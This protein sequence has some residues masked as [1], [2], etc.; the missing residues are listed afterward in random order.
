L[1]QEN[2]VPRCFLLIV[3]LLAFVTTVTAA[4]QDEDLQRAL[5]LE[6]TVQKII[7]RAEPA[8]ACLVISRSD[9]YARFGQGPAADNAGKLGPFDA[10]VLK[11]HRLFAELSAADKKALVRKLDL[12]ASGQVPEAS[13]SGIVIADKGQI[14]TPYHAVY[15]AT[16]IFVRLPE[17][18]GSYA[19]VFAADPRSDL[20]VLRLLRPK[21]ALKSVQ[22][23]D[24]GKVERGQFVVG[25]ANAFA[26]GFPDAKPS[27]AWGMI[28][29]VRQRLPLIPDGDAKGKSI[30]HY[31]TL[32]QTD[33][34][35]NLGTS[36]GVLFN[37]QGEAIAL[38]STV[39]GGTPGPDVAGTFAIPFDDGLRRII[40]VLQKG[41][42]VEYGFLGV[43]F[44]PHSDKTEGVVLK[45]VTDGSPAD[46]GG[47]KE[48]HA[49]MAVDGQP[50]RDN[51]ELLRALSTRLAGTKVRLDVKKPGVAARDTVEIILAKYLVTGK[52]IA[53]ERGSR[54]FFRG[55]RVD[56]T[57]LI[58]QQPGFTAGVIPRGVL[59]SE[60]MPDT[61]AARAALK[62]GQVVTHVNDR[63]VTTP[64]AFYD[65]VLSQ[66]GPVELTLQAS[67]TGQ[68]APKV[69]LP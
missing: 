8:V 57:S 41:E 67:E 21:L 38:T 18:Q 44:E 59:V 58:A 47:L 49:I 22:L 28:A 3:T 12:A 53:S 9:L 48:G 2:S 40:G 69:T 6:K 61:V 5:A 46:L 31:G 20:A 60:V 26:P 13:A 56:Y 25:L 63:P 4:Q 43:S 50:V 65:A 1:P 15:G 52:V 30:H 62:P 45:S 68:P 55:L 17:G 66:R 14:L 32:L 36:G 16:K 19:D 27:A 35:L 24:G 33:A 29:N 11:T 51:D 7:A 10:E 54:P 37:L 23:G 42:E 39:A 64:A 34:R